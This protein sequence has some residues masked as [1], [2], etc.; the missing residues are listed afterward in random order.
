MQYS[1]WTILEY[2]CE[3]WAPKIFMTARPVQQ[4]N[5]IGQNFCKQLRND[6]CG[7]GNLVFRKKYP[8]F[9]SFW[10]YRQYICSHMWYWITWEEILTNETCMNLFCCKIYYFVSTTKHI[11]R[12]HCLLA[13]KMWW[14]MKRFHLPRKY[15]MEKGR[16]L[17]ERSYKTYV[18]F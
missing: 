2:E 11:L 3:N 9:N 12:N 5:V 1:D 16:P 15:I 7:D 18:T 8:W 13:S 14:F 17:L 6:Q 10:Y 4:N